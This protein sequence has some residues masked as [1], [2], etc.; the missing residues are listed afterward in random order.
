MKIFLE[1]NFMYLVTLKILFSITTPHKTHHHTTGKPPK[2]HHTHHHNNNNKIRDQREK[3]KNQNHKQILLQKFQTRMRTN[4]CEWVCRCEWVCQGSSMRVG[5]RCEWVRWCE[6]VH[7]CEWVRGATI[8]L[9]SLSLSSRVVR[10]WRD[11][12]DDQ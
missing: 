4:W 1:N 8:S 12:L 7:R 9:L 6:W 11:D 2:H 5:L 3:V 10:K